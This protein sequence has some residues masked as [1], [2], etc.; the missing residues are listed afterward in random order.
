I[1]RDAE[2]DVAK[3]PPARE[4]LHRL[5]LRAVADEEERDLLAPRQERGGLQKRLESVVVRVRPD[6]DEG[7]LAAKTPSLEQVLVGG[8]RPEE[9][10]VGTVRKERDLGRRDPSA[11][12]MLDEAV[13][14]GR[15]LPG[16]PEEE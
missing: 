11:L 7:L 16:L 14:D 5:S 2:D 13:G 12:E 10:R 1:G 6:V 3:T 8:Q 9:V 15:D 4:R